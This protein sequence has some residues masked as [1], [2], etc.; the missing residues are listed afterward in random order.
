MKG[1]FPNL[2]GATVIVL[3]DVSNTIE[4]FFF[5]DAFILMELEQIFL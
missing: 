4:K 3:L 1:K 5:T 2:K